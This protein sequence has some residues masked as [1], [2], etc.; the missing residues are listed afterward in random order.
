MAHACGTMPAGSAWQPIG[1]QFALPN[2]YV[3]RTSH[4]RSCSRGLDAAPALLSE[5]AIDGRGMAPLPR[6]TDWET[7]DALDGVL[8]R[9]V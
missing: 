4:P 9:N 6:K 8:I 5:E 3:E 1:A 2:A 7:N